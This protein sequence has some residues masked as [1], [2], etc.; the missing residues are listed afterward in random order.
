MAVTRTQEQ[1]EAELELT[2]AIERMTRAYTEDLTEGGAGMYLMDWFV[3]TAR[4]GVDEDAAE[5]YD[6][7]MPGGSIPTY[8]AL[9]LIKSAERIVIDTTG[10]MEQV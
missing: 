6:V 2:A 9:G 4:A 3:I 5:S 1:I 8:R 10:G 7:F